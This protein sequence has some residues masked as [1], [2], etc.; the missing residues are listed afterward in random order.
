M[1]KRKYCIIKITCFA[2]QRKDVCVLK[3]K[4]KRIFVSCVLA[5]AKAISCVGEAMQGLSLIH[6]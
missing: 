2:A 1:L 3:F 6:I 5:K 4:G